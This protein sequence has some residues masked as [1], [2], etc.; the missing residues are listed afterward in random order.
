MLIRALKAPA[1]GGCVRCG[2]LG[3][4]PVPDKL[5]A[6]SEQEMRLAIH[7]GQT[8]RTNVLRA[9]DISQMPEMLF[10]IVRRWRCNLSEIGD[11]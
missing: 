3:M 1:I 8:V 10:L 2:Q 11:E 4:L 5:E 7:F 9:I 6:E